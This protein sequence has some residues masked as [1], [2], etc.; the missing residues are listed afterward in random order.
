MHYIKVVL[1]QTEGVAP[2]RMCGVINYRGWALVYEPVMFW[3]LWLS[4]FENFHMIRFLEIML[5]VKNPVNLL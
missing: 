4:T 5:E 3:F 1:L 2:Q